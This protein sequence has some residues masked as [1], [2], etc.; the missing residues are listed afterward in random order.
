MQA[1]LKTSTETPDKNI[2]M[3][4]AIGKELEDL[5][6]FDEAFDYFKKG[7]DTVNSIARYDVKNDIQL[8]DTIIETCSEQWLSTDK[9]IEPIDRHARTPIFIVGLPRTGTTLT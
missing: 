7:G 3:Y 4:Y 9:D 6:R 1:V 2:F 5:G 8:I